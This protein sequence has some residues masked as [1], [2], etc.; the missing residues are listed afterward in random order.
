MSNKRSSFI[1]SDWFIG[2]SITAL[3]LYAV[4]MSWFDELDRRAYELGAQIS[5]AKEPREDIL[6]IGIDDKSLESL[7][8]WPWSRDVLAQFTLLLNQGKPKVV[9]FHLPFE[10]GQNRSG[11]SAL[12]DLRTTLQREKKLNSRLNRSLRRIESSL[13]SDDKLAQAL[14]KGGDVVLAMS[15][16]ET[17]KPIA[18][19]VPS[20]PAHLEEFVLPNVNVNTAYS[21]GY[22]WP[23]PRI[24]RAE[25]LYPPIETL[26]R[27]AGAVGTISETSRFNHLPLIVRY[28]TEAF[29]S[30]ELMLTALSKDM[31]TRDIEYFTSAGAVLGGKKLGTDV[32]LNIYPRYYEDR[33]NKPAFKH[34]SFMDVYGKTVPASTFEDKV[35]IVGLTSPRLSKML[36]APNGKLIPAAEAAAHT[37]SSLL[38]NDG[39]TLPNWAIWSQRGVIAFVGIYLIF[40]I[41]RFRPNTATFFSGFLLLMILNAQFV[42]MSASGIWL[43]MVSAALMLVLGHL[44]ISTRNL[45]DQRLSRVENDLAL[46]NRELGQALQ[47]QGQL[48]QAFEKFRS[49]ETDETLLSL[50]YNLGLDYERKRMYNKAATV[51]KFIRNH[52]VGFNDVLDRI[53]KNEQAANAITL[54]G[55]GSTG[56]AD[57]LLK[58]GPGV[59]KPKLGRYE[60]DSEIGKGAMGMVYLGHDE[61]IGR[62]VAIKTMVLSDDLEADE[63]A[64]VKERF[65]REAEAAGRLDHPNIVTVYDVGEEEDLAYIAM[66]YLKGKDLTAYSS[67]PKVLLPVSE[68][69]H[70]VSSVAMA[71][72]YAHQHHVV[73]R[74]V[75]PANIIY[76]SRKRV[77][78]IT[79]FGVACL[80]DAS[81]TRTGTVMGSPYY[82]APE[83]LAG[84]RVDGR[85]DL[86]ALGVT[87]YQLLTGELPFTGES[88][89]NLMYNIANEPH[90]DIRRYRGD[91]PNC[92][93]T[94]INKALQK[95]VE[96]R[97][98]TGKEMALAMRMCR[99]HIAEMEA[100]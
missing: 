5:S 73:H 51:F 44:I 8:A 88:M 46:A 74:D 54:P 9:G 19:L 82:M 18:G 24:T 87:L 17:V 20:L 70:I 10:S 69:F 60:V 48:D 64:E 83:Q 72:N 23:R 95:E 75:K 26:S 41:K 59:Q 100:A 39:Y 68:V 84:K 52:D 58:S 56:P 1:K 92:I 62:T 98:Q 12:L 28:G 65:F 31:T 33:S 25:V 49:S 86:F 97:F 63:R 45:F 66:D 29:P 79:D 21:L 85:A 3:F 14:K 55:G 34:Y 90:P 40:F 94:V 7:G 76:D 38:N 61:K 81:K 50:V 22:G 43:P 37:V 80:T 4:E 47:A 53:Q 42:L 2:L 6:L 89:A 27:Q 13:L 30:F 15:Y 57:K 11:V 35:V 96:Q 93:G 78:K 67:S 77:A 91:L 99:E 16:V 36:T 32:D 71:L